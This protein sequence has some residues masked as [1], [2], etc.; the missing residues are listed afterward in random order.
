MAKYVAAADHDRLERCRKLI[1]KAIQ[2]NQQRRP[3]P[4]GGAGHVERHGH[5][6][7]ATQQHG[8]QPGAHHCGGA[9]AGRDRQANSNAA[10][11]ERVQS[12][13]RLEVA[14]LAV[15]YDNVKSTSGHVTPGKRQPARAQE[16][17]AGGHVAEGA[18]RN[19]EGDAQKIACAAESDIER[20]GHEP[21]VPRQ[22]LQPA[23]RQGRRA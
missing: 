15:G 18:G 5:G 23:D 13:R 6:T 11:Q 19:G 7:N 1:A 2:R 22:G 14:G 4:A 16:H 20:H 3:P 17:V 21:D 8:S 9:G 10:N 12:Q